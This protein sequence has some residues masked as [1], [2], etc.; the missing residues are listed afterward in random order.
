MDGY[1][2]C[3]MAKPKPDSLSF[4]SHR[5][6]PY[7]PKELITPTKTSGPSFRRSFNPEILF[8]TNGSV[9]ATYRF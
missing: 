4:T 2:K 5:L 7:F 8:N 3:A 6:P 1:E 9:E